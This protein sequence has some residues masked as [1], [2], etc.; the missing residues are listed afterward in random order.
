MRLLLDTHAFLWWMEGSPA[1]GA[2]A[3]TLVSDPENDILISIASLWE[4]I[5]KRTLGKLA[6]PADPENVVRDEE[7]AVLPIAFSHLRRLGELP[8][9]HRDPF[10]RMLI[11]QA[12]AEGV[13]IATADRRF[14][15]Y[16]VATVW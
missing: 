11:A 1:L 4:L 16:G 9:L 2:A 13:P 3:R 10:D 15:A 7:F 14:A 8:P 12:Q 5:I 6:F